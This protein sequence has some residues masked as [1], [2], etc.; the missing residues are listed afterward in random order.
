[1]KI[2]Y[3]KRTHSFIS[4]P[5]RLIRYIWDW[6]LY[7]I[8]FRK[9]RK[10]RH[11]PHVFFGHTR[12]YYEHLIFSI[13]IHAVFFLMLMIFVGGGIVLGFG[14]QVAIATLLGF[15]VYFIVSLK[16]VYRQGILKTLFKSVILFIM[17]VYSFIMILV[18]TGMFKFALS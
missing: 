4:Y 13:H 7:L 12:Y 10:Y 15:F 16:T 1:L 11:I 9:I 5:F 6:I 2:I 14:G 18:F 8:R 17:Y 3:S